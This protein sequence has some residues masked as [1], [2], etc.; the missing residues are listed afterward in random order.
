MGCG[1]ILI[2]AHYWNRG[3]LSEEPEYRLAKVRPITVCE[4]GSV[5]VHSVSF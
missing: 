4:Q 3:A 2:L 1:D 5:P